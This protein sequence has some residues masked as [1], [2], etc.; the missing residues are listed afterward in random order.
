[1]QVK[2]QLRHQVIPHPWYAWSDVRCSP[3]AGVLTANPALN[4]LSSVQVEHFCRWLTCGQSIVLMRTGPQC[5]YSLVLEHW[6]RDGLI[7][8]MSVQDMLACPALTSSLLDMHARSRGP[9]GSL[10]VPRAL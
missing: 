3:L 4:L 2:V 7:G 5:S 8:A 6:G 1:M 9:V 10:P